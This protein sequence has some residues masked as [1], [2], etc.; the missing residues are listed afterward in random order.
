MRIFDAISGES[1]RFSTTLYVLVFPGRT[2]R[3]D[4]P[5]Y[6]VKFFIPSLQYSKTKASAYSWP[7][8]LPKRPWVWTAVTRC[9][10]PRSTSMNSLVSESIRPL[11]H[12]AP[13]AVSTFSLALLGPTELGSWLEEAEIISGLIRPSSTPSGPEQVAARRRKDYLGNLK[14]SDAA[15]SFQL[16]QDH[17]FDLFLQQFFSVEGG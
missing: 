9:G 16:A 14:G 11:G 6:L 1:M 3:P 13:P 8:P 10:W 4:R 5:K 17:L 2:D 15:Q 7:W 12:Q